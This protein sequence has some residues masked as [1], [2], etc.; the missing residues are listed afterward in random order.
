[1]TLVQSY[2][3]VDYLKS[4]PST[5]FVIICFL[6][7]FLIAKPIYDTIKKKSEL[8]SSKLMIDCIVSETPFYVYN[9]LSLG[10]EHIALKAEEKFY[11]DPNFS[12][13]IFHKIICSSG[14][15]GYINKKSNFKRQE[16]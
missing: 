10:S 6:L 12:H 7:Y 11:L 13:P 5:V 4:N 15:I 3:I 14:Q 8:S 1:M 16:K 2:G 9:Q